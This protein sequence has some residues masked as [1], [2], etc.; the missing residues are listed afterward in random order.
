MRKLLCLI[1]NRSS[2]RASYAMNCSSSINDETTLF[3]SN[4]NNAVPLFNIFSI[5]LSI[6]YP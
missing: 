4:K 1:Q 3:V 5:F 6:R 2:G